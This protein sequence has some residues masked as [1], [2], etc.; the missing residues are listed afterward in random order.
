MKVVLR[1]MLVLAALTLGY[2][3]ASNAATLLFDNYTP[4]S[5]SFGAPGSLTGV[6]GSQF[7]VGDQSLLVTRLGTFSVADGADLSVGIWRVS[8]QTLMGS[9]DVPWKSGTVIEGWNFGSV[10]PFTLAANTAYRIGA[11]VQTKT[12]AWGGNYDKGS[13][14][15]S[16]SPGYL[17]SGSPLLTYPTQPG[18]G[19]FLAANAEIMPV[20]EPSSVVLLILGLAG[21]WFARRRA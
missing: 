9:V 4:P 1:V 12:V 10:T 16:I 6:W 15:A 18:S 20:P 8:D 17:W 11:E 2:V 14:I 7:L 13:G 21:L 5:V 3:P 19:L